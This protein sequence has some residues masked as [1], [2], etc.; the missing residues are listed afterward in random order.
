MN[1]KDHGYKGGAPNHWTDGNHKPFATA[2]NKPIVLYKRPDSDHL[3]SASQSSLD[4]GVRK[5][6]TFVP[7]KVLTIVILRFMII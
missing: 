4:G 2:E 1:V 3:F 6:A 7:L 5:P